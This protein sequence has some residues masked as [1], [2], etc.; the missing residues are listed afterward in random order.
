M[1]FAIVGM[2]VIGRI[3]AHV[4][5]ELQ[6]AQLAAV[7]DY[8]AGRAEKAAEEFCCQGTTELSD[9]LKRPDIDAV[10]I[11]VPSGL[12][13]Q[14]A[15][16]A[17]KA[18]KHVLLEKPIEVTLEAADRM[19][20]TCAKHGVRLGVIFQ[21]RFD[22]AVQ[23]LKQTVQD[24]ALGTIHFAASR[25]CW[26][27]DPQYYKGSWRGTL[28]LDGGGALINQSIHYI[29]LLQYIAGEVEW[30]CGKVD[31][32]RHRSIEGE[33]IG[34]ALLRFKNGAIGTIEGTTLAY[35]DKT[36]ELNIFG[37]KG[38]VRIE[39][40]RTKFF[41]FQGDL[42]SL[43]QNSTEDT[44]TLIREDVNIIPH[45]RQYQDFCAAIA[46]N[47]TPLVDGQEAR[48]SL[49]I[50]QAIYQ[51]SKTGGWVSLASL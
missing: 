27:R 20:E 43:Y 51:S 35:G 13:S 11:C 37:E 7:V 28:K 38:S 12:H 50:I 39:N 18:G 25:T 36:T 2:G 24:G 15:E 40:D 3:H 49:A 30:V 26:Y 16:Q 19:I 32:L 47:R 9:V 6:D 5:R 22:T 14:V 17:A 10:S 41:A 31:T 1:K 34:C 33:D 21:H 8:D 4:I 46:Q 45:K 48:K 23:A 44:E 29:D 42:P